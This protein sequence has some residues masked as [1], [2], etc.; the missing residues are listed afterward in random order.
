MKFIDQILEQARLTHWASILPAK[1]GYMLLSNQKYQTGSDYTT[2]ELENSLDSWITYNQWSSA[3]EARD[4]WQGNEC[5]CKD[6]ETTLLCD[7]NPYDKHQES[8]CNDCS[9]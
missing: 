5:I 4:E 1:E 2:I 9:R 3:R 7:H 6:C 8:I